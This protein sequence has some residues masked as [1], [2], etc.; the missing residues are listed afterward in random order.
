MEPSLPL[1]VA[2]RD[3]S[4]DIV[5]RSDVDLIGPFL[6]PQ[7]QHFRPMVVLEPNSDPVKEAAFFTDGSIVGASGGA[8]AVPHNGSLPSSS[9]LVPD[10]KSSTQCELVALLLAA[11]YG[12][13]SVYTDSQAALQMIK[14][15]FSWPLSKQLRCYYRGELRALFGH[16]QLKY[17]EKVK[18]HTGSHDEKSQWN[19][20]ADQLAGEAACRQNSPSLPS[21]FLLADPLSFYHNDRWIIDLDEFISNSWWEKQ[22][23]KLC[24][25]RN[26]TVGQIYANLSSDIDWRASNCMFTPP[27]VT[28]NGWIFK[29]LPSTAKWVARARAG[30]LATTVRVKK[31]WQHDISPVCPCCGHDDEDDRHLLT[32]CQATN[33][34]LV[35]KVAQDLWNELSPTNTG[36]PSSWFAK[37]Q[38]Q[39]S[40]SLIP[41]EARG[42]FLSQS[43]SQDK[44]LMKLALRLAENLAQICRQ[45]EAFRQA[46]TR[47]V[48]VSAS[49][50]G[51]NRQDLNLISSTVAPSSSSQTSSSQVAGLRRRRPSNINPVQILVDWLHNLGPYCVVDSSS[52]TA[53]CSEALLLLYEATQDI[54]C[55]LLGK[56]FSGKLR[57][58]TLLLKKAFAQAGP[59][60]SCY[61]PQKKSGPLAANAPRKRHW[62]FP[63][64]VA[65]PPENFKQKWKAYLADLLKKNLQRAHQSSQVQ[66]QKKRPRKSVS[67]RVFNRQ[68]V[69]REVSSSFSLSSLNTPHG[70]ATTAS[71]T[72]T[73]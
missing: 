34:V 60:F 18:A 9:V 22:K 35:V 54:L 16:P 73:I 20:K 3:L 47:R 21:N 4:I 59:P 46:G 5:L 30:A 25:R 39:L 58:W 72:Q 71:V 27:K 32:Q 51:L 65:N 31:T 10:P 67:S 7:Y 6:A 12:A 56:S 45:R 17:F 23:G 2:L 64:T 55:P 49:L 13:Q 28:P 8:A 57:G 69:E 53:W 42:F 29:C 26:Q 41:K 68:G 14:G 61:S 11:S 63:L 19:H 52:S 38:L 66:N 1:K 24:E 62:R 50:P 48:D 36:P 15:F 44:F 43:L 37:W 70:R 33:A 40:V